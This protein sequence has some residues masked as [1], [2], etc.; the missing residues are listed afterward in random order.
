MDLCSL[1]ERYLEALEKGELE[2][3]L[4]LFSSDAEVISP[5]YGR[6]KADKFYAKLLGDTQNSELHLHH[7]ICDRKANKLAIYFTYRWTLKDD[8]LLIFD[9][10]DILVLDS[11]HKIMEL[12]IIYDSRETSS[13]IA[14]LRQQE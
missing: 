6:L 13:K 9:V 11:D 2:G 4:N 7:S 8:S 5:V 1:G 3:I 12:S 14:S 10:V